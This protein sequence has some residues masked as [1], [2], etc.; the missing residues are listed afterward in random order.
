MKIVR[1]LTCSLAS[2]FISFATSQARP[3]DSEAVIAVSVIPS[4][5]FIEHA[6]DGTQALNFDFSLRNGSP[7]ALSLNRV[8]VSA[9]DAAGRLEYRRFLDSNGHP[10]A[11]K[12]LGAVKL[13]AHGRLTVFNPFSNLSSWITLSRLHYVFY[14]YRDLNAQYEAANEERIPID[15]DRSVG[16][17]VRPLVFHTKTPLHLPIHGPLIVWDGHDAYS[18]HRRFDI[19]TIQAEREGIREN[20]NLYAYDFV[21]VRGAN[22]AMY[23]GSP[24]DSKHWYGYGASEYAPGSGVVVSVA[25]DIPEIHYNG[26]RVIHPTIP[27]NKDP[28]GLGNHVIID[29]NDGEFSVLMHMKPGSVVVHL[30]EHVAQDQL[31]G[32]LGDSGDAIF[33]H[34][35]YALWNGPTPLIARGLPSSFE[36]FERV[37]GASRITMKRGQMDSGDIVQALP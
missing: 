10:P 30:G 20:S 8:E 29:H 16:I 23:D 13:P 37:V 34:L 32:Q 12:L 21:P 28:Y 1:F 27:D 19:S 17:D 35:H 33:P 3:G 22:A 26:H 36:H 15:Y 4:P 18:H 5:P 11:I 7:E 25:N 6:N 9:Y 31:L 2:L 24:Y 14:F